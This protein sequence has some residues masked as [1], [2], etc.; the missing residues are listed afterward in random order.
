MP[1][2]LTTFSRNGTIKEF[3]YNFKNWFSKEAPE[4]Y[5]EI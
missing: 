2:L 3:K 4:G 1:S 5:C